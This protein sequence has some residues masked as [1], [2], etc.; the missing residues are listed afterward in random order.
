MGSPVLPYNNDFFYRLLNVRLC[1]QEYQ[2]RADKPGFCSQRGWGCN[3]VESV[4]RWVTSDFFGKPFWYEY[5]YFQSDGI[6]VVQKQKIVSVL[7]EEARVKMVDQ[8]PAFNPDVIQS[9]V[10]GLPDFIYID[11]ENWEIV[12]KT[13]FRE[14]GPVRVPVG[15]LWRET[16]R[17]T[18]IFPFTHTKFSILNSFAF[19]PSI[20][21]IFFQPL[22][23][24][25]Y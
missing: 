19:M 15:I 24:K 22:P 8:C 10:D 17:T 7:L 6:W 2:G 20:L 12:Y 21:F 11:N 18:S 4:A 16:P 1:F 9:A 14:N 3:R 13:D 23:G 5:G 25:F